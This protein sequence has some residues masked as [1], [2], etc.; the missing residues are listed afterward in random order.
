M[1][2]LLNEFR[3]R[4]SD[5][6]G[7]LIRGAKKKSALFIGVS[8]T[9]IKNWLRGYDGYGLPCEPSAKFHPKI[10]E[11]IMSN[12]SLAGRKPGPKKGSNSHSKK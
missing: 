9:T 6:G 4:L 3:K 7:N 2:S 8:Q 5:N 1:E 10:R 12:K 11:L